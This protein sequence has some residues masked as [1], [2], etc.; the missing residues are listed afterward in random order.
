M[1]FLQ[2]QGI[3]YEYLDPALISIKIC[4]HMVPLARE[5]HSGWCVV[6]ALTGFALGRGIE[7]DSAVAP[8][9]ERVASLSKTSR[10]L[11]VAL[12]DYRGERC[13]V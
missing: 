8:G 4:S 10:L 6:V 3:V 11:Q 7:F 2:H 9:P 13:W 5:Y 12:V 1:A